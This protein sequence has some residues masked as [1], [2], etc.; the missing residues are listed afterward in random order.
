MGDRTTQ[1]EK[2]AFS[3]QQARAA[4]PPPPS[5]FPQLVALPIRILPH[6][7]K[8]QQ[9]KSWPK[10][11]ASSAMP[12]KTANRSAPLPTVAAAQATSTPAQAP[13]AP[14]TTCAPQRSNNHTIPPV[15]EEQATS[16]PT[17]TPPT[18]AWPKT[19]KRRNTT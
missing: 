1:K 14:P 9:S 10:N 8:Q 4:T 18:R 12:P 16:S 2:S 11:P 5:S 17:T 19:S 15:E 6:Y 7:D 3:D 13:S